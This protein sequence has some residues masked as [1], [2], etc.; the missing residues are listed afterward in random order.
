ML[1]KLPFLP[2]AAGPA[3]PLAG[4]L[5]HSVPYLGPNSG[6]SISSCVTTDPT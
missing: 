5:G 2:C 6:S 4:K 1:R 3:L